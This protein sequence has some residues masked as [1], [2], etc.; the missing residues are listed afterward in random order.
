M[1]WRP[2]KHI[3]GARARSTGKPCGRPAGWGTSHQGYGSCKLHGGCTATGIKAAEHAMAE[4]AIITYGLPREVDPHEALLEE[5]HRT[6]GAV[7]Y[8]GGRAVS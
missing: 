8:A 6:A 4:Q 2:P 1:T 7:A 3:C 5:L